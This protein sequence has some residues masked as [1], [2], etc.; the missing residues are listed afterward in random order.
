MNQADNLFDVWTVRMQL[1]EYP[2]K[3]GESGVRLTEHRT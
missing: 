1:P 2:N 3:M